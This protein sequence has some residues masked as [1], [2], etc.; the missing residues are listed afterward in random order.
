MKP[1]NVFS[2]SYYVRR[3]IHANPEKGILERKADQGHEKQI[4]V[5]AYSQEAA[6][7]HAQTV[8]HSQEIGGSKE[9][10]DREIT[11]TGVQ[12]GTR[13][14]H[15]FVAPPAV[16]VEDG[17]TVFTQEQVDAKVAE[18]LKEAAEAQTAQAKA[19][20]PVVPAK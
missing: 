4:H 5:A 12:Q 17:S 11:V 3:L 10:A 1:H 15:V 18:A 14:V 16:V 6:V 9:A 19:A 8:I 13:A 20:A 7:A 2:I